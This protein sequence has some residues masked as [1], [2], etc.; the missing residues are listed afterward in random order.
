[1]SEQDD[2]QGGVFHQDDESYDENGDYKRIYNSS[3]A[4]IRSAPN[5][6][7]FGRLNSSYEV[8]SEYGIGGYF[9]AYIGEILS[10][11]YVIIKKLGIGPYASTYLARDCK[12]EIFVAIKVYKSAPMYKTIAANECNVLLQLEKHKSD[13]SIE[14]NVVKLLNVFRHQSA[15]G[16]HPCLVLEYLGPSLGCPSMDVERSTEDFGRFNKNIHRRVLEGLN[17]L[18]SASI[19]HSDIKAT[20]VRI[21]VPTIMMDAITQR[22]WSAE[23]ACGSLMLSQHRLLIAKNQQKTSF[24]MSTLL[25]GLD[26]TKIQQLIQNQSHNQHQ[27][28]NKK[29][30]KKLKKKAKKQKKRE[31]HDIYVNLVKFRSSEIKL[32]TVSGKLLRSGAFAAYIWKHAYRSKSASG[33]LQSADY[34][35]PPLRRT[36]TIGV[37]ESLCFL[38]EVM[39]DQRVP[40]PVVNSSISRLYKSLKEDGLCRFKICGFSNSSIGPISSDQIS[41]KQ[42]AYTQSHRS[43][44]LILKSAYTGKTDIWAAGCLFFRTFTGYDL[45]NP[46]KSVGELLKRKQPSSMPIPKVH[47][48]LFEDF[49]HLVQIVSFLGK[50]PATFLASTHRWYKFFTKAGDLIIKV[51]DRTMNS[52]IRVDAKSSNLIEAVEE[53]LSRLHLNKPGLAEAFVQFL[54]HTMHTDPAYRL[55]G[56]DLLRHSWFGQHGKIATQTQ[57]ETQDHRERL[58]SV[59]ET[60]SSCE[61][62]DNLAWHRARK[63]YSK[64]IPSAQI[65][66]SPDVSKREFEA[67]DSSMQSDEEFLGQFLGYSAKDEFQQGLLDLSFQQRQLFTPVQR[68]AFVDLNL[69]DRKELYTKIYGYEGPQAI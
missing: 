44:E 30:R 37:F 13:P 47:P 39:D 19:V 66:E 7:N 69:L 60:G 57:A 53:S 68:N 56:E 27:S 64:V 14:T 31:E 29:E 22:H 41:T 33:R 55:A 11:R 34:E 1:M 24:S 3:A 43:P 15:T 52:E 61:N 6:D 26:L 8:F 18:H 48:S 16:F 5:T 58:A 40:S 42:N 21:S 10:N 54:K 59:D 51:K 23:R 36:Q 9:A 17:T 45:F 49:N 4:Q 38:N 20:K 35:K 63:Y 25:P 12:I 46:N 32:H 28:L 65:R 67:S 62:S 2:Y 50:I